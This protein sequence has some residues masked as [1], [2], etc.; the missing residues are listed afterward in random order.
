MYYTITITVIIIIVIIIILLNRKSKPKIVYSTDDFPVIKILEENW[1]T[2]ANEMK[3]L[4]STDV[5]IMNKTRVQTDW[6]DDTSMNDLAELHSTNHGWVKG[7]NNG[8]KQDENK[9]YNWALFYKGKPLGTNA[10]MC[11]V[12]TKLLSKIKGV[13]VAG[14]SLMKPNSRIRPHTDSTG[15]KFNS[16]GYHL[17][18]DIPNGVDCNLKVGNMIVKEQNGKAFLFDATN[19]HSAYNPNNKDRTIL[20]VDFNLDQIKRK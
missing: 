13:N 15:V 5:L 7:W 9:W 16:L 10:K 8:F 6:L 3:Q 12:T 14:F 1:P 19:I 20:Y 17:G 2:I 18:L 11:P 4:P